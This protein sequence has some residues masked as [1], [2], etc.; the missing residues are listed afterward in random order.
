MR[1]VGTDAIR[2]VDVD[3][4]PFPLCVACSPAGCER[5]VCSRHARDRRVRVVVVYTWICPGTECS[6]ILL[7]CFKRDAAG[8]RALILSGTALC[9]VEA[10]PGSSDVWEVR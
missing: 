1:D 4:G 3:G 9:H 8:C 10:L 5:T 2:R 6:L 7:V